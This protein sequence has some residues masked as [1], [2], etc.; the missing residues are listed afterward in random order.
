MR[1][2]LL[3]VF[4]STCTSVRAQDASAP[5]PYDVSEQILRMVGRAPAG[6]YHF[7]LV[8][9]TSE[10]TLA[11]DGTLSFRRSSGEGD[12]LHLSID[13]DS[14]GDPE[15][16]VTNQ[17][18]TWYYSARTD[19]VYQ[20]STGAM[21]HES[22]SAVMH[23][24]SPAINPE[25]IALY[26]LRATNVTSA[27]QG[28]C[29]L[30][31]S[32][33][34]PPLNNLRRARV[35]ADADGGIAYIHYDMLSG[36]DLFD[37]RYAITD[38]R[39]APQPDSLFYDLQASRRVD[40]QRPDALLPTS[41]TPAPTFALRDE[42][43]TTVNLSDYAGRVVLLDFWGTWCAPCIAAL[44]EMEQ[45]HS[46]Y[47]D[48]GLV[49]LG[50]ASYESDDADPTA[51]AREGGATYPILVGGETVANDFGVT[52]FPTYVVVG[53]DGTVRFAEHAPEP[54]LLRAALDAALTD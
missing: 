18:G 21:L 53:R 43:G 27:V 7:S 19:A 31:T 52:S 39:F 10:D 48:D 2:F 16:W 49:V 38:A 17:N 45:L 37:V 22:P 26:F 12:V 41:G 29:T 28:H 47:A 11:S 44:P 40:M 34:S 35:C 20:D 14:G 42:T 13:T 6:Q 51:V 32:T 54:G 4:V 30:L 33:F 1:L 8:I 46:D 50:V 36:A 9:T 5:D 3:L 23:L 25:M 24:L 15:R